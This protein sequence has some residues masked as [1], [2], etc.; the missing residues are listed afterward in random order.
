MSG[1]HDQDLS[2]AIASLHSQ[3]GEELLSA[4][5]RIPTSEVLAL[6][7]GR[8]RATKTTTD[9]VYYLSKVIEYLSGTYNTFG[10]QRWFL[11]SRGQLDRR[12]PLEHLLSKPDWMPDDGAA[13][14]VARLALA[15]S[16]M[17]AT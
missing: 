17:L 1:Q 4:L 16:T 15:S 10:V 3:L 8:E 6:T 5:L 7:R 11:R 9:R 12:S 13:I 14:E 2:K